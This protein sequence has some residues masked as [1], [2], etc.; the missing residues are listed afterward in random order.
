MYGHK[1]T[2]QFGES[3]NTTWVAC[4][5]NLNDIDIKQGLESCLKNYPV[6]P[7]GAAQFRA[8]CEGSELWQHR[9]D[10]YKSFNDPTHE[11]YQPKQIESDEAK[12]RKKEAAKTGIREA[13]NILGINT[14]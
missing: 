14:K 9:S 6:W 12:Q 2:S 4:L 13:F 1:F 7:P 3:V 10:A 5:V 8:L 11:Y